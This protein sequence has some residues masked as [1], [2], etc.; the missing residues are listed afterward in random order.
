MVCRRVT[1]VAGSVLHDDDIPL[2]RFSPSARR[3]AYLE[4][5]V[6]KLQIWQE[7]CGALFYEL[8]QVAQVDSPA[9]ISTSESIVL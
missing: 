2:T 5:K 7:D 1:T 3:F 6:L 4:T 9:T 8:K